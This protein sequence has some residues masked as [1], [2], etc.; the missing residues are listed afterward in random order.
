[1]ARLIYKQRH[2]SPCMKQP[3]SYNFVGTILHIMA[4]ISKLF[5]DHQGLAIRNHG[6]AIK[7][8]S[9]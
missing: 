7:Q 6:Y 4:D 8:D 2:R 5:E 1:M 3:A 9:I